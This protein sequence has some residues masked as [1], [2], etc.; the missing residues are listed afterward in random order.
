MKLTRNLFAALVLATFS[1]APAVAQEWIF[2]L[3]YSSFSRPGAT[4]SAQLAVEY[5][6]TP[7]L[8]KGRF[9]A[10]PAGVISVQ[11]EGDVFI[12][13]GVA[14]RF[15]F[16]NNWFIET[17]V[18]PGAFFEGPD[19][20]DLG[21]T[22]EIR[23]LLGVGYDFENGQAMSLAIL[24]KSNASTADINPGVNTILLRWHRRF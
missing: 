7:F 23:S 2:G 12:G 14:G 19:L 10:R 21:S 18:M 11:T 16:D 22:F 8:E 3:G 9:T 1:A 13:A 6:H 5:Q 24:H 15:S 17:S 4:D 20:N